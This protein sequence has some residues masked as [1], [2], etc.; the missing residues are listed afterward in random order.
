M[1]KNSTKMLFLATLI[2][3]TLLVMSANNWMAMWMGLEI[4]M[5][6][7][8]ALVS[9]NNNSSSSESMM[10]YFLIQ[11]LGS[12]VLLMMILMNSMMM[13]NSTVMLS[14]VKNILMISLMLKLGAAPFHSWMPEIMEKMSWL[15]C[16]ILLSW[17]KLAPLTVMSNI[18]EGSNLI[19]IAAMM[20]TITGA[21][22]GINQ[23]STRKIMAFSSISHMGWMMASMKFE[24]EMW[25][26]YLIVYSMI[27]V[28]TSIMFNY[29]STY[30]INQIPMNYKSVMEKIMYSTMFMS[31]GGLP[32]FIGFMPKWII[33][34]SMMEKELYLTITVLMLTTLIT[35]FYYLR[36][37]STLIL[38]SYSINKWMIVLKKQS[39]VVQLMLICPNLMLPLVSIFNFL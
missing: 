16:A 29:Y 28:T 6:A 17:Q 25:M 35:L 22:G 1:M 27:T 5:I 24:N 21:I 10:L 33:I 26:L 8:I 34:Q 9:K 19:L 7:F 31:L 12:I 36:M 2:G 18:M 4:N 39:K 14:L 15:N 3:S 23:T 38:L 20:S 30:H 13:I 11:S 32:P 37:I